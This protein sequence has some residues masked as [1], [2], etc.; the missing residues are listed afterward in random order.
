MES[1]IFSP[2]NPAEWKVWSG[3]APPFRS[4]PKAGDSASPGIRATNEGRQRQPP[5]RAEKPTAGV[6]L[7]KL[8]LRDPAGSGPGHRYIARSAA[9]AGCFAWGGGTA[10]SPARLAPYVY[11]TGLRLPRLEPATR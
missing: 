6:P 3:R 11:T 8:L 10:G 1:E 9:S 5:R 2:G 7:P 4:W